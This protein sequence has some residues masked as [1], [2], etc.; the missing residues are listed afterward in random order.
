[1]RNLFLCFHYEPSFDSLSKAK[2]F[3][4]P[5][6]GGRKRQK[7]VPLMMVPT[8]PILTALAGLALAGALPAAATERTARRAEA[9]RVLLKI[10]I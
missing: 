3:H 8:W 6:T 9:M 7:L 1:M 5:A 2:V 10:I 4:S